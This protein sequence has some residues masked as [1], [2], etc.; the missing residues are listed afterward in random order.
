MSASEIKLTPIRQSVFDILQKESS[1]I[2]A[3]D[4][5]DMLKKSKD[6]AVPMTVYRALDFL[7]EN[8]LIHKVEN[9][10][11]YMVCGHPSHNHICQL[12][13][14]ENCGK[15]I[16]SCDSELGKLVTSKAEAAGFKISRAT[17]EIAAVCSPCQKSSH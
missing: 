9:L 2:G 3:Y 8:N 12:I 7:I 13:I 1:P 4:I 5:L 14:C 11:A 6:N 15:T 10:N 17:L 16:E